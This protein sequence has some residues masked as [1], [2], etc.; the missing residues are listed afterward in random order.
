VTHGMVAAAYN[1]ARP[2]DGAVAMTAPDS[3]YTDFRPRH[4]SVCRQGNGSTVL[5][6]SVGAV[7]LFPPE[8]RQKWTV[9]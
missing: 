8:R 1:S 2:D 3:G 5:M 4:A 6:T 7:F 9:A